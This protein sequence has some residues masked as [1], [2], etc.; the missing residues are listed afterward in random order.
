ML[1]VKGHELDVVQP[2]GGD[3]HRAEPFTNG[4]FVTVYLSPRDYHRVH[5]PIDGTLT[6]TAY[7]PGELFSVSLACAHIWPLRT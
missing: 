1:Q 5:M 4:S 2:L 3:K 6:A 7:V